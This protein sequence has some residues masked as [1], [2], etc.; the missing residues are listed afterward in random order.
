MGAEMSTISLEYVKVPVS[1]TEN[2]A[3]QDPTG[4]VVQMA[5]VA[6]GSTP[7]GP[8][9]VNASWETVGPRSFNARTLVGPTAKVL[10][11]GTYKVW[12]KITDSPE[13]PAK[14]APG[15]LRIL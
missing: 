5:F 7:T 11:A 12:V 6:S 10:V 2:G 8:D 9:W 1:F 3:V 4:D 14:P 13:I 15:F